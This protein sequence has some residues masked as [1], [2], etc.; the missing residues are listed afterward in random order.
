MTKKRSAKPRKKAAKKKA[1]TKRAPRKKTAKKK[2]VGKKPAAKKVAKK[3]G[4]KKKAVRKKAAPKATRKKVAKK[5]AAPKKKAA[6]KPPSN[7][8]S[9]HRY[10]ELSISQISLDTGYTRETVSKRL[11]DAGI[12]PSRKRRGYPVYMLKE[13][14]PA[15]YQQ[16]E[17]EMDPDKLKPFERRAYYQGELDKLKLQAERGELVP[18]FEVERKLARLFKL[19]TQHLDTLPDVLERDV[20]ATPRQLAY[21]ERAIDQ[22]RDAMY[23]EVI[24]DEDD[25]ADSAAQKRG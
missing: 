12:Q 8:V 3:R 25:D 1:A 17:G 16:F 5:A 21:V 15:L 6:G 10:T 11:A 4:S 2:A 19:L 7:V 22:V 9:I 24:E 18:S 13:V 14:L 20:G 23:L